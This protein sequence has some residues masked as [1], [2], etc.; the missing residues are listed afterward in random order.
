MLRQRR[1]V[2]EA[3]V[4]RLVAELESCRPLVHVHAQLGESLAECAELRARCNAL[5]LDL[6]RAVDHAERAESRLRELEG[7]ADS[8][9]VLAQLFAARAAEAR[10]RER[11]EGIALELN[12]ARLAL[13]NRREQ[14]ERASLASVQRAVGTGAQFSAREA[15]ERARSGQ[16]LAS[17]AEAAKRWVGLSEATQAAPP[18]LQQQR[19]RQQL[20]ARAQS[21]PT[22]DGEY[23]DV[24]VR[25]HGLGGDMDTAAGG[26]AS[27][28]GAGNADEALNAKLR[29][30]RES[31]RQTLPRAAAEPRQ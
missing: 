23:D 22:S 18:T 5:V 3:E 31:F 8:E 14:A 25:K 7:G 1:A 15:E 24:P 20:P 29:E 2:G 19:R 9:G 10:Q 26:G 16:A 28:K 11:A 4:A 30:L 21:T 27:G 13:S 12:S 17:A 6:E